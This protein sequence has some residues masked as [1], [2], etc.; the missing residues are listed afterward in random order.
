[1]HVACECSFALLCVVCM[2]RAYVRVHNV[3]ATCM[4]SK[5][6]V[7]VRRVAAACAQVSEVEA[8][9]EALGAERTAG[10]KQIA[11]FARAVATAEERI[12]E[13]DATIAELRRRLELKLEAAEAKGRRHAAY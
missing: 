1:M 12:A 2:Y 6:E 9:L 11:S 8:R 4:L 10:V 13:R 7:L 5:T 3:H